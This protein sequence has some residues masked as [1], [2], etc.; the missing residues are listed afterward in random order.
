MEI[1]LFRGPVLSADPF[2]R[3]PQ[4]PHVQQAS[5]PRAESAVPRVVEQAAPQLR[6]VAVRPSWVRV[7]AADGTVIFEGTLDSGQGYDIPATQDPPTLRAGE[8]GAIYFALNGQHYGPVG[9]RG[10]VTSKLPLSIFEITD[11]YSVADLQQD[12]D[13]A[14]MVAEAQTQPVDQ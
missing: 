10:E 9:N 1:C 6:M 4:L 12:G 14:K 2:F 5:G 11:R 13:L 7:S 8:S 3:T